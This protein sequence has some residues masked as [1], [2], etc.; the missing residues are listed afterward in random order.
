MGRTFLPDDQVCLGTLYYRYN[1][2]YRDKYYEENKDLVKEKS[3]NKYQNNS[4]YRELQLKMKKDR[5]NN[6]P[7]YRA[8][9]NKED[10]E[11]YYKKKN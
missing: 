1:K 10:K 7:E 3:R 9:R 6:D 2:D 4:E 11:R 5:Y 8:R